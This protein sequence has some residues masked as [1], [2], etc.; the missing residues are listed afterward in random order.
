MSEIP[1]LYFPGMKFNLLQ[2]NADKLVRRRG[3][4]DKFLKAVLSCK[5][6]TMV[7][8][9]DVLSFL[10][11]FDNLSIDPGTSPFTYEAGAGKGDRFGNN[12]AQS[13]SNVMNDGNSG[14]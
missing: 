11:A 8:H 5:T 14:G 7:L 10:E 12:S 6:M 3:K 9:C 2:M 1:D 4:L 13:S